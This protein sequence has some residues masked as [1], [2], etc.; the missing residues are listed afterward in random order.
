MDYK[1]K[2]KSDIDTQPFSDVI[3]ESV[4]KVASEIQTF[5]AAGYEFYSER[6]LRQFS[7]P[8]KQVKSVEDV[9]EEVLRVRKG[10]AGL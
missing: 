6:E 2:S 7:K 5:R 4:T 1:G 8:E 3:I 9:L 10:E